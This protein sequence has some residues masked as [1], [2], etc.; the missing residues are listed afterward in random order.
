MALVETG[1]YVEIVEGAPMGVMPRPQ[2]FFDGGRPLS[3]ADLAERGVLPLFHDKPDVDATTHWLVERGRDHWMV[4]VDKVLSPFLAYAVVQHPIRDV[5]NDYE[6]LPADQWVFDDATMTVTQHR[7]VP[8]TAA[9]SRDKALGYLA[10]DRWSYEVGGIAY[11]RPTDGKTYGLSTDRDSQAKLAAERTAALAGLRLP[12]DVW[13]CLDLATNAPVWVPFS[14][15]EIIEIAGMA[16]AHVAGA[17]RREGELAALI[18]AGD[19]T[20]VWSP[21]EA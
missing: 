19:V 17:F 1:M 4:E 8:L 20:V 3:D 16:R 18:M 12:S 10:A 11:T 5:A 6:A 7:V 21:P 2:W 15:A 13:K 14:D 9:Q